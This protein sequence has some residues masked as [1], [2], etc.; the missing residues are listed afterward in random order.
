[1]KKISVYEIITN[2]I[3]EQLEKGVVP[4]RMPWS[5]NGLARNWKSQRAYRGINAMLLSPGEYLTFKQV[6]AAGGNVKKGAKGQPIVF[7]KF[8][9]SEN[10]ETGEEKKYAMIRYY[11][12]FHIDDTEGIESKVIE[13]EFNHDPILTAETIV[14]N[15]KDCPAVVYA[16]GRALY[17]PKT[18][19]ISVPDINEYKHPEEYYS[20]LFHELA[21]STGHKS[22]LNRV[23]IVE[24]DGF[25]S[26]QYSEE[27]L[28]A[29]M[30]AAMLCGVARIE[31]TTLENSTAYIGSWLKKFKSDPRMIVK[32]GSAAQKAADYIQGISFEDGDE[33]EA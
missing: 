29:E 25:G 11:I 3:I 15:Y 6:K 24:Y 16:P 31:N 27:E 26:T 1:M 19:E 12:V 20:T 4:W 9:K 5:I 28:V 32:A 23:G 33:G 18:D 30:T 22:R 7:W 14:K 13:N 8:I 21:H 10:S 17:R 2:R